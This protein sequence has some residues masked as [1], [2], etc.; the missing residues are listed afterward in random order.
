MCHSTN[1]SDC[2]LIGDFIELSDTPVFRYHTDFG[3]FVSRF[4]L[5]SRQSLFSGEQ[6]LHGT[7]FDLAFFG[8][9]R[10]KRL[11]QGIG[12]AEGIGDGGL[13][14]FGW[15]D[16]IYKFFYFIKRKPCNCIPRH[17]LAYALLARL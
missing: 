1:K 3:L 5:E 17:S 14:G 11:N 8:D 10:G 12:I 2:Y 4:Y 7:L 6:D 16:W 9:E 13:F 15:W